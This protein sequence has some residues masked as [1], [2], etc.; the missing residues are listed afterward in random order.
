MVV[1]FQKGDG[2]PF[3][4]NSAGSRIGKY[5][6]QSICFVHACDNNMIYPD[7][8][9][10]LGRGARLYIGQLVCRSII[11]NRISDQKRV[12][13]AHSRHLNNTKQ[14]DN[15]NI[16]LRSNADWKS[17]QRIIQQGDCGRIISLTSGGGTPLMIISLWQAIF[18]RGARSTNNLNKVK[19]SITFLS[20][21]NLISEIMRLGRLPQ[22]I[23][24]IILLIYG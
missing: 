19:V 12:I 15:I 8:P 1:W 18:T 7:T 9:A 24:T 4:S 3:G 11:L 13:I 16:G 23:L 5:R 22:N 20:V 17:R 21:S 6:Q 2:F 10:V 14:Y